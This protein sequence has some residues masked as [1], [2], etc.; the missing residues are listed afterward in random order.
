[1]SATGHDT[2]PTTYRPNAKYVLLLGSMTALPAIATDI[3]LPS[4]PDVAREMGTTAT[5]VQ[6]TMT[7][8]LIGGAVV[9]VGDLRRLAVRPR[10]RQIERLVEPPDVGLEQLAGAVPG[11]VR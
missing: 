9:V 1:M 5:A 8:T 11:A 4:L 10:V 3:Y 2:G 6:L 7:A